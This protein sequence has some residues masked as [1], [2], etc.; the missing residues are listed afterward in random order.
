MSVRMKLFIALA[1]AFAA[2]AGAAQAGD[3][4][5]VADAVEL[6]GGGASNGVNWRTGL[7]MA[8]DEINQAGGLLGS[9]LRLDVRGGPS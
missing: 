5:L 6:S 2:L 7:Y 8:A 1:V 9:A 3:S 4:I